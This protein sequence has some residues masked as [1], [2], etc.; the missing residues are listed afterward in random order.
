MAAWPYNTT[1]WRDLRLAH[2]S[3]FPTCEGC[4]AMGRLTRAN[5][6]D[7]RVPISDGGP[8]FPGHDGLAS[9]CGPCHGAKTARGTEAGAIKSNR[10]RKGCDVN[11]W[12]LDP[13]HPWR[14]GKSL[15]AD[16]KGPTPT[17][18]TQ[19]VSKDNRNG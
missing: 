11:G 9:Y 2:L 4:E 14:G 5:T 17:T 12:P 18:Q 8:A 15:R 1:A 13:D 7:H 19:L 16:A 10:P 6:V 3:R